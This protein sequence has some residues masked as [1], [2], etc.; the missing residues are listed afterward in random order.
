MQ[1]INATYINN[2]TIKLEFDDH[3]K[4]I[5]NFLPTLKKYPN[6]SKFL[7]ITSF[8]KFKIDS[9]NIVW[10]KN[11]DMIFTVESLYNNQL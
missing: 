4:N 7:D 5:I 11:W 9:G 6:C 3:K 1:V 10:G 2:F 8:K